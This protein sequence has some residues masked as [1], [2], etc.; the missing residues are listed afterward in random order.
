MVLALP[1]LH[2][3][4][5][6]KLFSARDALALICRRRRRLSAVGE[7]EDAALRSAAPEAVRAA[8]SNQTREVR[9]GR[10]AQQA[11]G[12]DQGDGGAE[13]GVR[14]GEGDGEGPGGGEAEEAGVGPAQGGEEEGEELVV[15]EGLGGREERVGGEAVAPEVVQ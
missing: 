15:E 8:G 5:I 1:H 6:I 14:S 4:H 12:R 11:S 10:G 7:L 2:G 3:L 9:D 13:G